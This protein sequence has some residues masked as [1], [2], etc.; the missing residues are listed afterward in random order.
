MHT[1]LTECAL[2][3]NTGSNSELNLK[4]YLFFHYLAFIYLCAENLHK[5]TSPAVWLRGT[6]TVPHYHSTGPAI[7]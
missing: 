1:Q 3:I 4:I 6:E 2:L 7:P 5:Y